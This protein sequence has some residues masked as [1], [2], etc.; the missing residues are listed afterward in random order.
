MRVS[1]VY[2]AIDALR[3]GIPFDAPALSTARGAIQTAASGFFV[4]VIGLLLGL[5]IPGLE[6]RVVDART[7]RLVKSAALVVAVITLA[8]AAAP[9]R[10]VWD[11]FEVVRFEGREAFVVGVTADEVFLV[12]PLVR[13]R[14]FGLVARDH[15]GLQR[16]G[17][18]RRIFEAR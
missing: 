10:I 15:P 17:A 9:R 8:M 14:T 2:V 11:A 13:D 3:N 5:W 6:T 7:V 18:V 12:A 1:D 4:L 16:T